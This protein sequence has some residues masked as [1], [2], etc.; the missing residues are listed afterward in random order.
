[1]RVLPDHG[2][3]L[4]LEENYSYTY[5]HWSGWGGGGTLDSGTYQIKGD[6][7]MLFSQ[8]A[9]SLNKSY[10]M[11]KKRLKPKENW[12]VLDLIEPSAQNKDGLQNKKKRKK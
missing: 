2:W 3:T 11:L 7:L 4:K 5:V 10:V 6:T 8:I 9:D 12:G 1:M